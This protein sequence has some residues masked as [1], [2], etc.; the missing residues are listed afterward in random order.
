SLICCPGHGELYLKTVA[1]NIKDQEEV[2]IR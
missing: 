1:S 2:M